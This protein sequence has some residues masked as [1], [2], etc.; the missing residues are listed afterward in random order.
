MKKLLLIL[1]CLPLLFSSCKKEDEEPQPLS[2]EDI[3]V[4]TEW[5]L[6][7]ANEDGFLLAEDGKF[8]LTEKCQSNTLI[9]NWII[10]GDLIKY[11]TISGTQE[12]TNLWAEVTEYS[13][14]QVKLLDDSNSTS[15]IVSVYSPDPYD[16]YGCTNVSA[17]N[18]NPSAE[19]DDGSCNY[20]QADVVFYGGLYAASYFESMGI[21]FLDVFVGVGNDDDMIYAGTLQVS[22]GF[23]YVP[24]CY[25]IDPD[26][27]HFTF[28]SE[29][30]ETS[31]FF[32]WKLLGVDNSATYGSGSASIE[33]ND[34]L[35]INIETGW[36]FK[37]SIAK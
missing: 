23:A 21:D 11:K 33:G 12:I 29:T 2:L 32:V 27:V 18:Y 8:Y 36:P 15:M 37:G 19:C 24:L 3:I 26:A 1:L 22:L 16:I 30:S 7:N 31:Q 4:G 13:N 5:C 9:G 35:P 20:F 25:P 6:S 28:I 34:C 14:T 17:P 10:D